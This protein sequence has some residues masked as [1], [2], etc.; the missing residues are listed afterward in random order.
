MGQSQSNKFDK[1]F[2]LVCS[3]NTV[4]LER[5]IRSCSSSEQKANL[6]NLAD[7]NQGM[8]L[9]MYAAFY[10]NITICRLLIESGAQ[11]CRRD[12]T[13]RNALFYAVTSQSYDVVKYLL[14]TIDNDTRSNFINNKDS[15]GETCLHE[16]VKIHAVSCIELLLKFDIDVNIVNNDGVTAL[17]RAVDL[18]T[19]YFTNRLRS[20][21]L[22]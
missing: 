15:T 17:H 18:G 4:E 8:T 3:N 2:L 21:F 12:N 10:G 13:E 19:S 11:L 7:S 20:I 6:S 9:L 1:L 14:E 22:F 5:Q 16:A